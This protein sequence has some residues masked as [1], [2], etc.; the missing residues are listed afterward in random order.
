MYTNVLRE[1]RGW[2]W[3]LFSGVQIQDKKQ[4]AQTETWEV[5]SEYEEK[6]TFCEGDG[7]QKAAQRAYGV[8]FSGDTYNS[9]ECFLLQFTVGNL[10]YQSAGLDDAQKSLLTPKTEIL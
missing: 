8:S 5:P 6:L 2:D 10:L 1:S 4:Q 3:F 7:A 9:S